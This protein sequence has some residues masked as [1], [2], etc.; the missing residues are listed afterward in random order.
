MAKQSKN[1]IGKIPPNILEAEEAVLGCILI[2]T[3]AMAK[4]MQILDKND[5]YNTANA[6]IY[7]GMIF[8][9]EKNHQ[10]DYVS[11]IEQLKKNKVLKDVGDA[12]YI[13]ALTEK[14]PSAHNVEYYAKLVKEKSILRNIINVSRGLAT[15]AY[16]SKEDV[17]E[18][19]DNAE[20][21][22]FSLSKE[23]R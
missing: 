19:L 4:S 3:E 18:I 16:E 14:A 21:A 2:D 13:T 5:F 9:F 15:E 20:Q 6:T 8:L 7:E 23:L 12:Y 10:I 11:I 17:T 22:L 1:I